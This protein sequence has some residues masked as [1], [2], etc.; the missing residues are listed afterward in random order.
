MVTLLDR[1]TAL[2]YKKARN[3]FSPDSDTNPLKHDIT[4]GFR[5]RDLQVREEEQRE[6][7]IL[8][9]SRKFCYIMTPTLST[10]IG[11]TIGFRTRDFQ[12]S[13]DLNTQDITLIKKV[14]SHGGKTVQL[15]DCNY[16]YMTKYESYIEL[17]FM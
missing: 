9:E 16:T 8:Q 2:R 3:L 11:I 13:R 14:E 7:K 12:V 1:R 6:K 15:N 5:T 4:I 17:K 10:T